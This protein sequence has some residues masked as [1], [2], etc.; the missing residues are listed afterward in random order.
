MG[1]GS[2]DWIYWHIFT[3]TLNYNGSPTE[4]LLNDVC[5]TNLH[6]EYLVNLRLISPTLELTNALPSIPATEPG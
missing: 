2:D 6:E 3:I 5:L 1:S 4:L